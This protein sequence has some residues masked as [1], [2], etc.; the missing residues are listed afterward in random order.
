MADQR[1]GRCALNA[2]QQ[3]L[4]RGSAPKDS[5]ISFHHGSNTELLVDHCLVPRTHTRAVSNPRPP[6]DRRAAKL[7]FFSPS[8]PRPA[9]RRKRSQTATQKIEAADTNRGLID[10]DLCFGPSL[11]KLQPSEHGGDVEPQQHAPDLT[12]RCGC[13][14]PNYRHRAEIPIPTMYMPA[15]SPIPTPAGRAAGG[16]EERP[17]R[18]VGDS[19]SW[20]RERERCRSLFPFFSS[21]WFSYSKE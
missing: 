3:R 15:A 14:T 9:G 4:I 17:R 16:E 6:P 5:S 11:H 19:Q 12:R 18:S 1:T 13:S 7:P 2:A 20:V 10:G 21:F 8:P